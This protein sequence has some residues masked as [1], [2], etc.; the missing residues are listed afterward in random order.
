MGSGIVFLFG[1]IGVFLLGMIVMTD[2]LKR[3]A[4][5]SVR[6]ALARFTK[7]PLKGVATGAIATAVVQSSSAITVTAV[8]F[9]GAGLLTFPQ[10]VSVVF[11]ANIGTTVT[12]WLVTLIGFKLKLGAVMLPMV[13]V[14]VLLRLFGRGR[15]ADIGWS[16]AGFGLLFFGLEMMQ[17]AMAG[18][19]GA[20]TP[21]SFPRGGLFARLQLVFVG[22]AITIV[23]QSSSA[24][25]A[26]ALVALGAGV[27]S[28]P[29]AA[30]LV[31][32]MDVGTTV[33]ALLATVGGSVA[34][35]R[36]GVA[37]FA[38]NVL[39]G[40][41]AFFNLGLYVMLFED[42]IASGHAQ[43]ALVC[44]HTLSNTLG[45]VLLLPVIRPFTRLVMRL[46]PE[47]GPQLVQRLDEGLLEQPSSAIDAAA[48]TVRA[49]AMATA[50]NVA[51][52]LDP[53]RRQHA[54]TA[55]LGDI[56]EAL[57][58]TRD[59][60]NR[61]RARPALPDAYHRHLAV[62]HALDHLFR[63]AHRCTQTER[64]AALPRDPRL[65][66]LAGLL[67]GAILRMLAGEDAAVCEARF[68]KL[69]RLMRRQREAFRER[70]VEKAASQVVG[71]ETTL[72]RLDA[73]R[74]LHRVAYH[75]WRIS[76]HL[77]AAA[78]VAPAADVTPPPPRSESARPPA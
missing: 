65:R 28:F 39:S 22:M 44:F 51:E 42:F 77:R 25:V 49:I 37:H 57:R 66:R 55:P 24:G 78:A 73:M 27:V 21:D 48:A 63:L 23:T 74:W 14:G 33:T 12:G 19:E 3:L 67:D 7:T 6:Q 60:V 52:A 72:Q 43:I 18:L 46:A 4:G 16:L 35:R 69:R 30:A 71:A 40:T 29:Q 47:K 54:A 34:M 75:F 17:Q 56:D 5:G 36:T 45:V 15:L 26:T 68:D 59:F 11:G 53:Q 50:G 9:V 1:G 64:M 61:I 38:F 10:A 41:V 20:V 76:H 70:A 8:G 32:G 2:G 58:E 31:I 13:F 62:M